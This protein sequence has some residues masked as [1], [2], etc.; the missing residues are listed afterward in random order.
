LQEAYR[1]FGYEEGDMHLTEWLTG[2]VISLPMH[3]ELTDEQQVFI[4]DA[5]KAYLTA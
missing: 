5:V 4:A 3:T 2:Q 1:Q